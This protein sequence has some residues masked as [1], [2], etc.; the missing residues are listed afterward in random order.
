ME[1]CEQTWLDLENVEVWSEVF[2][3]TTRTSKTPDNYKAKV[4][5][6]HVQI[7]LVAPNEPLMGC[8]RLPDWL[9]K[10]VVFMM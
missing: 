6:R 5:Y 8:E 3:P 4:I 1:K 2:L 10:Y 7:S 9:R